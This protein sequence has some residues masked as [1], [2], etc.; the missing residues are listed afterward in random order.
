M[1]KES[2]QVQLYSKEERRKL[3]LK[4]DSRCSNNQAEQLAILKALEAIKSLNRNSINPRMGTIFTDSRVSLDSLHNPNNHAFLVEEIRKKVASLER[5]QWKIMFSWVKAHIGIFVNELADKLA[6]EAARSDDT[7]YDF[8]RIPKSTLYQ[9]AAVETI[10]KWQAEWTT[11][12]KADATNLRDDAMCISGQGDQTMDHLLF[13]CTKTNA[14]RE[15]LKQRISQQGN[16]PARKQELISK[17]QN[18]FSAFIESIDFEL[19][20]Q[21]VQ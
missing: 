17:Y 18:V 8:D 11:C 12:H 15:V 20:Q 1:N 13:H 10:Q 5:S 3:K 14:K 19:L 7:S 2:G 16:W 9:E 6:K 21:S 4:L